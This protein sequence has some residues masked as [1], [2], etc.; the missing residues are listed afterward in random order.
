MRLL[1]VES[2]E[3]RTRVSITHVIT[4]HRPPAKGF[5]GHTFNGGPSDRL[6]RGFPASSNHRY[7]RP[8]WQHST[9]WVR[10]EELCSN[11]SNDV[12]VVLKVLLLTEDIAYE[13]FTGTAMR[14]P[15]PI[16]SYEV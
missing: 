14:M 2:L 5:S 9:F 10:R 16:G 13:S 12:H 8:G 11:R 4:S 6:N 1:G 15:S 7:M 3:V